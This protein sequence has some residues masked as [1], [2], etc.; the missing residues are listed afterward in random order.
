MVNG[1]TMEILGINYYYMFFG[2]VNLTID[3][4]RGKKNLKMLIKY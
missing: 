4:F 3:K 2:Y 1:R